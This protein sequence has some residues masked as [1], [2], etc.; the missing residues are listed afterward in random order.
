[1]LHIFQRLGKYV[2]LLTLLFD[3]VS[4]LEKRQNWVSVVHIG[5]YLMVNHH[6]W[7]NV[8]ERFSFASNK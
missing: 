5:D 8:E 2:E 7:V 4:A 1:M 6:G 3:G